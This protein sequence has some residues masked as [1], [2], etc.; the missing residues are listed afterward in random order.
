MNE[1]GEKNSVLAPT[2]PFPGGTWWFQRHL[3]GKEI[4]Q[5]SSKWLVC[6]QALILF[7]ESV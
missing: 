4:T 3:A 2:V 5:S 1:R 6:Y 7:K